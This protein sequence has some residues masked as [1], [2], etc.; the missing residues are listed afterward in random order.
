MIRRLSLAALAFIVLAGSACSPTSQSAAPAPQAQMLGDEGPLGLPSTNGLVVSQS[1]IGSRIGADILARGGNAVDAAIATG[2]AM[3]ITN[4]SNANLGG[5]GFM[6]VQ[7]PDGQTESLDFR[8]KAPLAATEDMYVDP[9]TGGSAWQSSG[10]RAPGVPGTVAGMYLAH[11]RHGSLPWAE[12]VMPAAELAAEG[13]VLPALGNALNRLT[14]DDG[15]MMAFPSS[16][17]VFA[18]PD[19]SPWEAEDRLRFPDLSRS[20]TAIAQDGPD[21]FYR[22]WIADSIAVDMSRNGGLITREDLARYEAEV[23]EPITTTYRDYDLAMMGPPSGGGVIVAQALNI[24]ENFDLRSMGETSPEA[25][26]LVLESMRRAFLDRARHLGDIDFNPDM[27]LARLTSKE[28]ASQ[29]AAEIDPNR[30]SVSA[31]LGADILT[32]AMLAESDETTHYSVIDGDGMAVSVTYTLE[33]GYGSAVVASGTGFLLNNEMGDFNRVP[34]LTNASG[35]VGTPPNRIAPEKRMLSSMTP[36]IVS[37]DG[38]VVLIT[39]SPGGRSIPSTVLSVVL[40][41][42]EF[43]RNGREAVDGPRI[44][45][46]WMP[47][48]GSVETDATPVI[49]QATID[50]LTAMGHEVRSGGGGQAHSIWVDETT[51]VA[52]GVADYRNS[53]ASA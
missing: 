27:P 35:S 13:V 24:L 10:Y 2:F 5:G 18:K 37:R 32:L 50:A 4:P 42:M 49:P 39:G 20:L 41:F 9:A 22:G 46:Q 16:M 33:G 15:R 29:L 34:G 17:R 44:N 12:V 53:S 3:V 1:E 25:V 47:D 11:Q 19:G 23:R 36:A 30:A 51:G 21:A 28:Y 6:I 48:R 38:Q 40:G 14:Q 45:H 7:L 8:E 26:H 52:Y 31:D 43:E